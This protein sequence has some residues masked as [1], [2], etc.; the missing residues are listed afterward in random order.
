MCERPIAPRIAAHV[1]P[2]DDTSSSGGVNAFKQ[3]VL[4]ADDIAQTRAYNRRAFSLVRKDKRPTSPS[5]LRFDNRT[6]QG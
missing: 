1:R 2:L 4:T 3:T 5:F 6:L